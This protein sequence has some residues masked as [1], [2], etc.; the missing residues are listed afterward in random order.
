MWKVPMIEELDVTVT[1]GGWTRQKE[2]GYRGQNGGITEPV[3][4]ED[5]T[6]EGYAQS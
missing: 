3:E 5:P 2:E 4:A 1:A 6:E